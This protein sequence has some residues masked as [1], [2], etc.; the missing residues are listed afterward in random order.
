MLVVQIGNGF[1]GFYLENFFW[2][3]GGGEAFNMYGRGPLGR[4]CKECTE[5]SNRP[6]SYENALL[7]FGS[8]IN[9]TSRE[10]VKC[11][12]I[13]GIIIFFFWGGEAGMSPPPPLDRT[14]LY[15]E[16]T[17]PSTLGWSVV[18]GLYKLITPPIPKSL[19]QPNLK[20]CVFIPSLLG[21]WRAQ[22]REHHSREPTGHCEAVGGPW[23]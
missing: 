14:L 3:G 10:K 8:I 13:G 20:W 1:T 15:L 21:T 2:G 23:S 16:Y 9:L 19:G 11:Q 18:I 7:S 4:F 6:I 12:Y 17:K 22:V 5:R